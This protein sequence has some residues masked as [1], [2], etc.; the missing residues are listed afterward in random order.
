[1]KIARSQLRQLVELAR[2]ALPGEAC[3]LLAG[4]DGRVQEVMPLTNVE[5]NPVGCGWRADSREQYRAF[6]RID[7]Q[8]WRL[9]GI[10]HSHPRSPA[11]PSDRDVEHALYPD[12]RYVIVSLADEKRPDV[13]AYRVSGG[14]VEDEPLTVEGA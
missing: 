8:G 14:R 1:M 12:A 5:H 7:E 6:Q 4:G 11:Y 13:R 10:Y 2:Q 3:G 9:L